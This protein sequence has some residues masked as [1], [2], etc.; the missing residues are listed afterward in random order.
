M[1]FQDEWSLDK[2][3][4][5]AS[6]SSSSSPSH[7]RNEATPTTREVHM[8]RIPPKLDAGSSDQWQAAI[9][10]MRTMV[11]RVVGT[12]HT[13]HKNRQSPVFLELWERFVDAPRCEHLAKRPL[14][15]ALLTVHFGVWLC[16]ACV[17]TFG[18]RW[19]SSRSSLGPIEEHTCDRCRRF[20]TD[21]TVAVI[22]EDIW[23][24]TAAI[25]KRCERDLVALGGQLRE[26]QQ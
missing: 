10:E 11:G 9:A 17:V 13:T 12:D 21:F 15:P 18:Q 25:C 16:R 24:F 14:Q 8:T 7:N 23:M 22:R 1:A 26:P 6:R 5:W 3:L 19:K 4:G 20:V 2:Q